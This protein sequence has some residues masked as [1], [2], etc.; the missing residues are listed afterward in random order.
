[1]Y[2]LIMS[3]VA[4]LSL[5]PPVLKTLSHRV[6]CLAS[7]VKQGGKMEEKVGEVNAEDF[8]NKQKRICPVRNI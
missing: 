3:L 1:M 7:P 2:L 4:S 5:M 6:A 8:R